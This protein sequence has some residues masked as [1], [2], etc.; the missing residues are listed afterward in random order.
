MLV[1][2]GSSWYKFW[3]LYTNSCF[4]H[5]ALPSTDIDM[6]NAVTDMLV[7]LDA[8]DTIFISEST[9]VLDLQNSDGPWAHING[10]VGFCG[11][12]FLI[13]DLKKCKNTNCKLL[14]LISL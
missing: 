3:D 8:Q 12:L 2:L 1:R 5:I 10:Q 6:C 14:L 4:F 13:L 9:R 7:N 11:L